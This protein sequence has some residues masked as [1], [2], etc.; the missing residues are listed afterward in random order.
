MMEAAC[1]V[2]AGL[3]LAAALFFWA[4]GTRNGR[5]GDLVAGPMI[6][7]VLC[8]IFFAVGG[9]GVSG[10]IGLFAAVFGAGTLL[11]SPLAK[12]NCPLAK[13]DRHAIGVGTII[14]GFYLSMML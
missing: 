5:K 3:L 9:C 8:A 1:C 7:A 11:L 4:R 6:L 14:V 13:R 12:P 10:L 2:L